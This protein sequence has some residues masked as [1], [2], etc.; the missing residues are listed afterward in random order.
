MKASCSMDIQVM[1]ACTSLH[2]CIEGARIFYT[3]PAM[4]LELSLFFAAE[5][6]LAQ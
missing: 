2:A 5:S 3:L 1:H 4:R 6:L